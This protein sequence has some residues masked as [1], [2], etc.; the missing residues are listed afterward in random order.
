MPD[1]SSSYTVTVTDTGGCSATSTINI[2]VKNPP[3]LTFTS[4]NVT[5]CSGSAAKLSLVAE[6]NNSSYKYYWAPTSGLDRPDV[7]NP[8]VT[9]SSS[10]Q[11]TVTVIDSR[12]CTVSDAVNVKVITPPLVSITPREI[13]ICTGNTAKLSVVVKAPH[14]TYKWSSGHTNDIV[15]VSPVTKSSYTVTVIDTL[16]CSATA[17]ATVYVNTRPIVSLAPLKVIICPD[18]SV[19]LLALGKG[20]TPAYKYTWSNGA[21]GVENIKV[22]PSISTPYTVTV[23]DGKGCTAAASVMVTVNAPIAA[24]IA[25]PRDT[26][27]L[28]S[29]IMLT[30]KASGTATG[31]FFKWAHVSGAQATAY[32]Q[33]ATTTTYYITATESSFLHCSATASATLYVRDTAIKPTAIFRTPVNGVATDGS[34]SLAIQGEHFGHNNTGAHWVWYQGNLKGLPIDSFKSVLTI[35]PVSTATYFA[36]AEGGCNNTAPLSITVTGTSKSIEP[37]PAA[38]TN[39]KPESRPDRKTELKPDP[40]PKP[41]PDTK[42]VPQPVNRHSDS[43]EVPLDTNAK[44]ADQSEDILEEES[45]MI[46]AQ[47]LYSFLQQYV[48]VASL[49]QDFNPLSTISAETAIGFRLLFDEQVILPDELRPSIDG[50]PTT[51]FAAATIDSYID[52]MVQRFPKG[53]Q[54]VVSRASIDFSNLIQN[55]TAVIYIEKV[56]KGVAAKPNG[57]PGTSIYKSHLFEMLTIQLDNEFSKAKITKVVLL[58]GNMACLDCADSTMPESKPAITKP[59]AIK[60]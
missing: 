41:K 55:K 28:G 45:K 13:D 30:A 4:R 24:A 39:L 16:G 58:K 5:L 44:S 50:Q 46:A 9:S 31:Y 15:D 60:K 21:D 56:V 22:S 19:Q 6:G 11:Y 8:Q 40:K 7:S 43:L 57:L 52:N 3:V 27:C 38:N 23:T 42:P 1:V 18:S 53:L 34:V 12:G 10:T 33:P 35:R 54:V 59:A 29:K 14:L 49:K 37:K 26:V 2:E 20:G 36:R 47:T 48:Q 17:S 32:A 51:V 25:Y